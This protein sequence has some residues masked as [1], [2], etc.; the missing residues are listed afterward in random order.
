M[1]GPG[2][3]IQAAA[4][5]TFASPLSWRV[6]RQYPNGYELSER[7][8]WRPQAHVERVWMP[9]E[10]GPEVARAR[11]TA[12]GRVFLDFARFPASHVVERR[13]DAVTVRIV[14]VRFV[15]TPV[16]LDGDPQARAPFVVTIQID[17]AG[18]IL[19]E[20]LGN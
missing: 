1:A 15:G 3:C 16:G 5:P 17:S 18:R 8:L 12:T 13:P 4:L 10:A 7:S 19:R 20:E 11:A 2:S 6:V 9:S 14:D